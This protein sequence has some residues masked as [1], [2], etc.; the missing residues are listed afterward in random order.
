MEDCDYGIEINGND[1][2][3]IVRTNTDITTELY[4]LDH[5]KRK[6]EEQEDKFIRILDYIIEAND[7]E[8]NLDTG[9]VF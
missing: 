3:F 7:F 8:F 6:S 4:S 5:A 9:E 1:R 2:C